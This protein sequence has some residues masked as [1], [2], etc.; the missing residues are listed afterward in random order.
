MEVKT[1]EI[2]DR[3]TFIPAMGIKMKDPDNLRN[4][5]LLKRA[6]YGQGVQDR[7]LIFLTRMNEHS[8]G[9]YDPYQW[10][11]RTMHEAHKYIEHHWNSLKTGSVIDV[12]LILGETD[13]PKVSEQEYDLFM[14]ERDEE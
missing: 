14:H 3:A 12:E 4:K 6:G 5:Y 13:K 9:N 8:I 10:P 1:F 7:T 2:L 11:N